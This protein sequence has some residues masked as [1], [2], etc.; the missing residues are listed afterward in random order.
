MKTLLLS[1]TLAFS[2]FTFVVAQTPEPSRDVDDLEMQK[3]TLLSELRIL[4]AELPDLDTPLAKALAKAEIADAAWDLDRKWANELVIDAYAL[5]FPADVEQKP[6]I[7]MA[8]GT[9]PKFPTTSD[10]ATEEIR[11]RIFAIASRDRSLLEKL[12]Q[13]GA[14]RIDRYE[15]GRLYGKLFRAGLDSGDNETALEFF[16]KALAAEPTAVGIGFDINQLAAQ[17]REAAD[18]LILQYLAA[19]R[20]VP[21][22]TANQ[23]YLGLFLNFIELLHPG[24]L[25]P[26]P[27]AVKIS[28]PGPAVFHSYVSCILDILGKLEQREPGSLKKTRSLL[29]M[30]W[31]PLRQYAPELTERFLALEAMSRRPDQDPSLPNGDIMREKTKDYAKKAMDDLKSDQPSDSS[32]SSVINLG[33]F[34]AARKAIAK[35]PNGPRKTAFVEK[36][37]LSEALSLAEKGELVKAEIIAESLAKA[38]SIQLVYPALIKIYVAKKDRAGATTLVNRAV[39]QMSKADATPAAMPAEMAALYPTIDEEFDPILQGLCAL[40]KS[41]IPLDAEAALTILDKIVSAANRSK[42]NTGLGRT[43]LDLPTFKAM[44]DIG[45][46]RVWQAGF[47][48]NDRLRRILTRTTVCQWKASELSKHSLKTRTPPPPTDPS[49]N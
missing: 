7:T 44:A 32:I 2:L 49:T 42:L 9:K 39:I 38:S 12:E 10:R 17:D 4:A 21:F 35:L 16:G 26:Q 8:I 15:Q 36:V 23:F 20:D 3:V 41:V 37:N 33:E 45:E 29:L 5:T 14:G 11:G 19:L 30:V 18:K 48:F 22:S 25:F 6:R 47:S 46:S 40:A 43:G 31:M 28:P 1:L 24:E 27:G 34:Q 13:Q